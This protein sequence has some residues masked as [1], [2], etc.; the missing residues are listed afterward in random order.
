MPCA[1]RPHTPRYYLVNEYGSHKRHHPTLWPEGHF[2]IDASGDVVEVYPRNIRHWVPRAPQQACSPPPSED[3]EETLRGALSHWSLHPRSLA[4]LPR[5]PRSYAGDRSGSHT[6]A[7]EHQGQGHSRHWKDGFDRPTYVQKKP[8]FRNSQH[9]Q[10]PRRPRVKPRFE[11]SLT[12]SDSMSAA[13]SSDQQNSSTDQYLQV[14][15]RHGRLP[16]CAGRGGRRKAS[17]RQELT[18][19]LNDLVCSH[20]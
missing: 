6:L 19:E 5:A 16:R 2:K 4:R 3:E 9:H 17:P 8:H 7:P 15:H 11:P 20:V 18:L 12:E 13:S 1:H 10:Y 14:T